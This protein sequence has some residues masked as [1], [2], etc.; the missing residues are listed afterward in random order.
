M[1]CYQ[2]YTEG[3]VATWKHVSI[4]N[5][6]HQ[7]VLLMPVKRMPHPDQVDPAAMAWQ[8]AQASTR[9][10][11]TTEVV[12]RGVSREPDGRRRE[13]RLFTDMATGR[14]TV[15]VWFQTGVE[16]LAARNEGLTLFAPRLA[17]AAGEEEQSA[18]ARRA[19]E[20]EK[21]KAPRRENRPE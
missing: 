4:P 19:R 12:M 16:A 15:R 2:L 6:G 5:Y 21:D 7:G 20:A 14:Q 13:L 18:G 17:G 10:M 11:G 8:T 9:S 1:I 3:N